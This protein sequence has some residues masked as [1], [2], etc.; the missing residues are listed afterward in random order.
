M[1][2]WFKS[3]H[4]LLKKFKMLQDKPTKT[5]NS[6]KEIVLHLGAEHLKTYKLKSAWEETNQELI[7]SIHHLEVIN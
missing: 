2:M 7:E 3:L 5:L 6:Y 4:D 1:L